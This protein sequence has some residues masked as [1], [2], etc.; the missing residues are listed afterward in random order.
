MISNSNCNIK[1]MFY[2]HQ[3]CKKHINKHCIIFFATKPANQLFNFFF[4]QSSD[5]FLHQLLSLHRFSTILRLMYNTSTVCSLIKNSS[6]ST[7]IMIT[8]K[9]TFFFELHHRCL[10]L[11]YTNNWTNW[12]RSLFLIRV[13]AR[14]NNW[15]FCQCQCS[16]YK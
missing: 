6:M 14:T 5:V 2:R 7:N 8:Q 9:L 11:N 13:N 3:R 4:R 1:L 10:L 16:L 15:Y 12:I